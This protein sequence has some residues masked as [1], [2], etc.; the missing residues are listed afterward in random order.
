MALSPNAP[1]YVSQV[2]GIIGDVR[3]N[4]LKKQQL[5]QQEQQAAAQVG[6]GYAQLAA[7]RDNQARQA[8]LDSQRIELEGIKNQRELE[9]L[10]YNRQRQAAADRLASDQFEL[11]Q[12]EKRQ[13]ID[14]IDRKNKEDAESGRIYSYI[15]DARNSG[16]PDQIA[17]AESALDNTALSSL[18]KMTMLDRL[19]IA[20]ERKRKVDDLVANR[21]KKPQADALL[22]QA[23][24]LAI[25]RMA[26]E[27]ASLALNDIET[28]FANL[29]MT[30]T[31]VNKFSQVLSQKN[32]ALA[33]LSSDAVL[34]GITQLNS[35]GAAG[36]I[37]DPKYQAR[38]DV[39][40]KQY[41]NW[42]DRIENPDAF[43]QLRG[44]AKDITKDSQQAYLDEMKT[45]FT[46]DQKNLVQKNASLGVET[47]DPITGEKRATFVRSMPNMNLTDR[48]IDP[49]TGVLTKVK[50]KEIVDYDQMLTRAMNGDYNA[51]QAMLGKALS[52]APANPNIKKLEFIPND[53]SNVAT[54]PGGTAPRTSGTASIP[55]TPRNQPTQISDST[56]A[57]IAE[58]YRRDPNAV[59]YGRPAREIL[60][61]LKARGYTIPGVDFPSSVVSPGKQ[62]DES[63]QNR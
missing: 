4:Y 9:S 36:N 1:D 56:L 52:E 41:P 24:N 54:A 53:S 46:V 45:K 49:R 57:T 58:A 6:L 61:T 22:V 18:T 28:Q 10:A 3:E 20:E 62:Y 63:G 17:M 11:A 33:K 47:T 40:K 23:A 16:D 26:P 55:I 15:R 59:I 13:K 39:I 30:D 60:A 48:D 7:Q 42:Q 14:E 19:D 25:D 29:G 32:A 51:M 21:Q 44:L 37:L 34:N 31:T 12:E 5:F 50:Q 27:D 38:Y 8:D 43:N 35:D 2:R